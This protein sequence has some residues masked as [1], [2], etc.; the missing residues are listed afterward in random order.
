[1][2]RIS[3]MTCG[4]QRRGAYQLALLAVVN[5]MSRVCKSRRAP[6]AD[7]DERQA[8]PIE[9]NQINLAPARTKVTR[10]GLQSTIDEIAKSEL[11]GVFA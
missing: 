4:E 11:L 10:D 8:I 1:M 6:A 2:L 7:L 5:S 9:Q 3:A